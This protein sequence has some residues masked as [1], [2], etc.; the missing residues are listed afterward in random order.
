MKKVDERI[1][2]MLNSLISKVD[3]LQPPAKEPKTKKPEIPH[4]IKWKGQYIT[5]SSGKTVWRKLGDAKCA[6]RQ[7]IT[8]DVRKT[9]REAWHLSNNE[10]PAQ[11]DIDNLYQLLLGSGV[12]EFVPFEA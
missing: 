7:E 5:L 2:D 1:E 12:V 10:Y 11:K 8:S 4:R 9:L 6:F 3:R